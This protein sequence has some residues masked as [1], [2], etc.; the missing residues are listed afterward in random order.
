VIA[1]PQRANAL[2]V[3]AILVGSAMPAVAQ[4]PPDPP[5]KKVTLGNSRPIEVMIRLIF[6]SIGKGCVIDKDVQGMMD[7]SEMPSNVSLEQVLHLIMRH[8]DPPIYYEIKD[9]VYYFHVKHLPAPNDVPQHITLNYSGPIKDALV[10]LFHQANFDEDDLI[11]SPGIQ[12]NITIDLTDV[13]FASALK[14]LLN[15][16]SSPLAYELKGRYIISVKPPATPSRT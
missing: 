12:G 1:F 11:I 7:A 9:D 14:T 3:T 13:S 16:A 5:A 6:A 4:A 2:I 10:Q 15:T 8:A